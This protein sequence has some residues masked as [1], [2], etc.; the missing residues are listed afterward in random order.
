MQKIE[1]KAQASAS[2]GF[3]L[4][5]ISFR[6]Y[7]M[8]II[9][10]V[11]WVVL[12]YLTGGKFLSARNLSNLTRAMSVT[13]ILAL[14]MFMIIVAG[15]IDLSVGS[16]CGL[17]GAVAA[18]L[19]VKMHWGTPAAIGAAL[20]VGGILGL[21]HGYWVAIKKVPAFIVTLGGLMAYRGIIMAVTKG[22]T[23]APLKSDFI[24]IGQA[25]VSNTLG[26]VIALVSVAVI[27]YL[28]IQK[29]QSRVKYGFEVESRTTMILKVAFAAVLIALFVYIMNYYKGIPLPVL[30]V[31]TLALVFVFITTK[32][33]FGRQVFAMG[34]NA[35]AARLSGINVK[36]RTLSIF[37]ISGVMAGIAGALL[38]SRLNAATTTAGNMYELDA[39]ASC[40]IGGT[41]L[42]GGE[43]YVLGAV[44]GALVMAS[45]DNGMS[46]MNAQSHWQ[47][48]VKGMILLFAVWIDIET[49]K[50]KA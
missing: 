11:T 28:Q 12:Q 40:V 3:S 16:L 49:K 18:L 22:V 15:H 44:I 20:V 27:I 35:E 41:S 6:K 19:Q 43:G 50:K 26:W 5:N 46:L 32:T 38:T 10:L 4:K 33:K 45:L 47:Y 39:V 13:A 23:V 8:I 29:R 1:T 48:I 42:V 36:L 9:L 31:L 7:S 37:V 21:W 25:Y 2:K 17:A 14:G 34:G 24:Y 30:L